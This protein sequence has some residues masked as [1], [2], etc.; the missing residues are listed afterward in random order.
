MEQEVAV[1][2][3]VWV[4]VAVAAVE[5]DVVAEASDQ[6]IP[7]TRIENNPYLEAA[8]TRIQNHPGTKR[9]LNRHPQNQLRPEFARAGYHQKYYQWTKTRFVVAANL[10]TVAER[11]SLL[12]NPSTSAYSRLLFPLLL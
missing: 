10:T 9:R 6:S 12:G 7:K 8:S 5:E 2:D 11:R 4:A 3:A 1:E